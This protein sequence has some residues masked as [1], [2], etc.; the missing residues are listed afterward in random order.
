M[1]TSNMISMGWGLGGGEARLPLLL[2][3]SP[4]APRNIKKIS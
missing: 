3:L 1:E 4:M 2:E